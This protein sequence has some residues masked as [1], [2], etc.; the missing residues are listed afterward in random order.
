MEELKALV[1]YR[2]REGVKAQMLAL[3]LSSRKNLCIN[4]AVVEEGSRESV[5]A[6]CQKLTAGW[7]RDR[8]VDSPDVELCSF[9]EEHEKRGADAV[10]P[11]GIYTMQDLRRFGRQKGWCPYF[12]ARHMIEFSNVVV[13]NYQY[14]LDPKVAGVVSRALEREC[15]VVFDEAHNIDNVCIE[16]LSVNLRA[17]TLETAERNIGRM[18]RAVDKAKEM[19]ASR[20]RQEYQ[21]LV[22][23]LAA[24]GSLPPNPGDN[25]QGGDWQ[26]RQT[27]GQVWPFGRSNPSLPADILREAVPGNI[28]RAEHFLA[29][30]RR[31]VGYLQARLRT[32]VVESESPA[33]FLQ[34]L[35][36]ATGID[37][38][39][40][41][42]S[43]ER[44]NSLLKT[45]EIS[46]TDDLGGIQLVADLAT[47]MGTYQQ[48]FAV[49][50]E[51]YDARLPSVPDPVLQL[52]CLDASLAVRPVFERFRSVVITS[53]T[54]SP[55][56]MFPKVLNFQP[57]VV[58]SL[59]MTLVRD[60]ICPAIYTKGND[61][62]PVSSKFDTRHDPN[63]IKNYGRMLV[64]LA[65][66]VPDGMVC[67]FVSY[68][69]MDQIVSKWNEMG[70]LAELMEKKLVF[71]ETQDVVET[72]L[73][74]DNFRRACDCGRGAVFLSIAR[75]KVAE[76]IDFD[77]H[78]GRAVVM[79]GIPFQYTLS[80]VLRARLEYL[81][82]A[83]QIPERD[84]LSFDAIRQV[85]QCMGR[86][87]RS[88]TDYGLMILADSRYV[89]HDKRDKLPGWI[90]SR[91]MD[92]HMN[93][94]TDM[95]VRVAREFMFNMAQPVVEGLAEG[96]H[97]L[98]GEEVARLGA[99][100]GAGAGAAGTLGAEAAT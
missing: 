73:A 3:G 14:M 7:V 11:P 96:Q 40:L 35:R 42:F 54:L 64:D 21:R 18:G 24:Q 78:Y 44:L 72:T 43:Y 25:S 89:R 5:D 56:D 79:F 98:R 41:R 2:E 90:S 36:E 12:L 13:Y 71:I 53:G 63:V 99:G 39:T 27:G 34:K 16:A 29:F 26:A 51:P 46:D 70:I 55:I 10:L 86:V 47:L 68:L 59:P 67:F 33:T 50:I 100:A 66:T 91:I 48:G 4:K 97:L 30:L 85:A 60:C 87:I 69:Y 38:K 84:F 28:R 81:R 92:S 57:V 88:K 31:L 45:L 77:H 1:E 65:G 8:A 52:C 6:K 80:R 83:F 19:D 20:L 17:K 82:E 32:E 15:V 74:L 22:Q 23:G 49:I 93:L 76:G 37:A 62:Q 9:F 58:Q 94:S 61:Q 95:L 75:G